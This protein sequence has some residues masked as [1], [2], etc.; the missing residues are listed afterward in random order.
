MKQQTSTFKR[1]F[2]ILTISLLFGI[3]GIAD[4]EAASFPTRG[5]IVVLPSEINDVY[6]LTPSSN[7]TLQLQSSSSTYYKDFFFTDADCKEVLQ[8]TA[9]YHSSGGFVYYFIMEKGKTYY[10]SMR[11]NTVQYEFSFMVSLNTSTAAPNPTFIY[12]ERNGKELPIYHISNAPEMQLIFNNK[13]TVFENALLEYETN[14]GEQ[15]SSELDILYIEYDNSWRI[16]VK[17]IIDQ[18]KSEIKNHS[19]M[20]IVLTNVRANG[21]KPTGQ[22]ADGDNVVFPYE[23]VSQT[24]CIQ[25]VWPNPFL[26]YWP[27]GDPAGIAVLTFDGELKPMSQQKYLEYGL[28]AGDDFESEDGMIPMPTPA[29]KIEGRT[30]TI[31]FTGVVYETDK[32]V[33]TMVVSGVEDV[34]NMPFVYGG[35][36]GITQYMP[37]ETLGHLTLAYELTPGQGQPLKGTDEIELWIDNDAWGHIAIEGF[38]FECGEET[39]NVAIESCT[40]EADPL[41]P[42]KYT[43]IYVPVP[44]AAKTTENVRM[45]ALLRSLDGTDYAIEVSYVNGPAT[46]GIEGVDAESGETVIYN[47]QGIRIK[48][49]K[50]PAGVY[51]VNGR[52][53]VVR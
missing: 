46:S 27:K 52:K 12:P 53:R 51:I 23:Y 21:A 37:Y 11:N 13:A 32:D 26:S 1:F 49:D 43:L 30:I 7:G 34:Y 45:T 28:Y 44:Q 29:L 42:E 41:D 33:M 31:D 6:T 18:L 39:E 8:P 25:A 22:F 47:L 16:F 38:A 19:V 48:G 20:K 2:G 14:D 5:S 10:F 35:T 3:L 40:R 36:N 50:L 17:N 4:V 9:Y 15:K 24:S